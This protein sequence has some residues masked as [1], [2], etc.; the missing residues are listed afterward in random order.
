VLQTLL[1]FVDPRKVQLD[2][3]SDSSARSGDAGDAGDADDCGVGGHAGRSVD[4]V[5]REGSSGDGGGVISE[6][7]GGEERPSHSR[8][9][10]CSIPAA[11]A[12]LDTGHGSCEGQPAVVS[13]DS[14]CTSSSYSS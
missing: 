1:L 4:N 2:G 3:H 11:C 14:T 6:D 13:L 12:V 9:S 8:G 5:A 7:D 10:C